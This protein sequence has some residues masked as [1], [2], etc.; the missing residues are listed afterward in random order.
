MTPTPHAP[1]PAPAPAKT[2]ITATTDFHSALDRAPDLVAR[3]HA[4]RPT[5][6]IVDS[7]DF[8]EGTHYPVTRGHIEQRI[9]TEVYDV[10]APGNHGWTHYITPPLRD[11]TVC[12]NVVD[13]AGALLFRPLHLAD[14]SGQTVAVTAVIGPNAFASIAPDLRAG[15]TVTDPATALHQLYERHYRNVDTWVLLSHQGYQRDQV[16]AG[17]CTF[18]DLVFSGHCHSTHTGPEASGTTTLVKAPEFGRGIATARLHHSRWTVS[19]EQTA[20]LAPPAALSWLTDAI[21]DAERALANVVGRPSSYW[22]G[23][24]LAPRKFSDAWPPGYV[25]RPA[26][27]S[28]STPVRSSPAPCETS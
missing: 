20:L 19:V 22:K 24:P 13:R 8:F 4:A 16:L 23:R 6:L 17:R 25:D 18:L 1:A 3:L 15:Q 12:A 27:V 5:S 2:L 11:L 7:G 14:V 10:I 28:S 21:S 26:S 9:L